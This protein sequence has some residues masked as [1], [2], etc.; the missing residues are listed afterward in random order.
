MLCPF[1]LDDIVNEIAKELSE[2]TKY[3]RANGLK[4]YSDKAQFVLK[5]LTQALKLKAENKV[6]EAN[7]LLEKV[8]DGPFSELKLYIAACKRHEQ[9][10]GLNTKITEG[11]TSKSACTSPLVR[12]RQSDQAP[13]SRG[14]NTKNSSGITPRSPSHP[15]PA[16]LLPKKRLRPQA[17]DRAAE[18]RG[19]RQRTESRS[20]SPHRDVRD[21][22]VEGMPEARLNLGFASIV[23]GAGALPKDIL[24]IVRSRGEGVVVVS[25]EPLGPP[26]SAIAGP[27]RVAGVP[28][29]ERTRFFEGLLHS[30][31]DLWGG[32]VLRGGCGVVLFRRIRVASLVVIREE[33]ISK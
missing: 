26:G 11:T 17:E 21:A 18:D 7:E 31:E 16:W 15:P 27:G 25:F 23:I 14:L 12:R 22:Y 30:V 2:W 8:Y 5:A 32:E 3:A 4:F 9:S 19:R 24:E 20:S 10:R 29:K 28:L 33:A 13:Q 6:V 1:L